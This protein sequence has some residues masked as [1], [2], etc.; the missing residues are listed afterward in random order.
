MVVELKDIV[1]KNKRILKLGD[2]VAKK[3]SKIIIRI[4]SEYDISQ[5]DSLYYEVC[6][7][8]HAVI[9]KSLF[10]YP[11]NKDQFIPHIKTDIEYCFNKENNEEKFASILNKIKK[12]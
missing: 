10:P 4:T 8:E 1:D 7:E 3:I 12:I 5:H 6:V 2:I 11:W 9:L